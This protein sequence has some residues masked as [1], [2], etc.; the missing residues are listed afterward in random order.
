MLGKI[1]LEKNIIL[2][3]IRN[4]TMYISHFKK[5]MVTLV[6]QKCISNKKYFSIFSTHSLKLDTIRNHSNYYP[7]QSCC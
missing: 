6:G 4:S 5:K 1:I 7:V 3:T 2:E